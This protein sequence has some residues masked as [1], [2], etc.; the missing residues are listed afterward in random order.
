MCMCVSAHMRLRTC[1][2]ACVHACVR[3]C[4]RVCMCVCV[5]VGVGVYEHASLLTLCAYDLGV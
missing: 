4:M 3:A 2:R 1:V 5:G